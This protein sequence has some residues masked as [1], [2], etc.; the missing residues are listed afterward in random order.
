METTIEF[1]DALI[2]WAEHRSNFKTERRY[3][4]DM[5][6]LT[7]VPVNTWWS[8]LLKGF[9]YETSR[10]ERVAF[11][12]KDNSYCITLHFPNKEMDDF[13]E[14]FRSSKEDRPLHVIR[15]FSNSPK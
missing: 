2:A 3:K 11:I 4:D 6:I 15:I 13:I 5:Q 9:D 12:S 14:N 10:W 8:K 7:L 1:R